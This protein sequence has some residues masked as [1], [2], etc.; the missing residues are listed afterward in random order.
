MDVPQIN[1]LLFFM[2]N[3]ALSKL[4]TVANTIDLVTEQNNPVHI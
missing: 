3:S 1:I 2:I 4:Q